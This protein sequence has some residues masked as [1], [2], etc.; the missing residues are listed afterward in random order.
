MNQSIEQA[1]SA[2]ENKQLV[3]IPTETVYGLAAPINNI[4]LIEKIF[5]LKKRPF[6]DPLICHISDTSQISLLSDDF[7]PLLSKLAQ[8]FWPGPLTFVVPKLGRVPDM[9]TAGLDTVAIRMPDHP[10][11]LELINELKIPLAAP[12]ANLFGKVSPTSET[13][14]TE[15][16]KPEDVFVLRGG[17]CKGG[18]ESTVV[19]LDKPKKQLVILRPGLVTLSMLSTN[20]DVLKSGYNVVYSSKS[21]QDSPGQLAHHYMP[22]K[23][24]CLIDESSN[25]D[26]IKSQ[27]S[28]FDYLQLPAEAV[29]AAR[30]LYGKLRAMDKKSGQAIL[31]KFESDW[32]GELWDSIKERLQKAASFDFRR[33]Q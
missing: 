6:Y 5:I 3:A 32:S 1:I 18:I 26:M 28:T 9:I 8:K 20:P 33:K 29:L 7:D 16:F 30:E 4:E 10:L 11:T 24:L 19:K 15:S 2:F 21:A 31:L 23:P 22:D 27:F 14:V 13:H 25:M 17:D 12:S